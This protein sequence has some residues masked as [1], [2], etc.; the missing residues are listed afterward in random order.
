MKHVCE[1]A[2]GRYCHR[3]ALAVQVNDGVQHLPFIA[4]VHVS[5][6]DSPATT[7]GLIGDNEIIPDNINFSN[8]R[9]LILL[10]F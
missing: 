3:A 4:A 7:S 6:R 8:V 2:K 10:I 1:T 5:V 9:I